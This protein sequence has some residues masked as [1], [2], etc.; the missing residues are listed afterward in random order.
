MVERSSDAHLKMRLEVLH[1]KTPQS[2]GCIGQT[3]CYERHFRI[4]QTFLLI[5]TSLLLQFVVPLQ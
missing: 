1:K 2:T 4:S 3:L 5:S